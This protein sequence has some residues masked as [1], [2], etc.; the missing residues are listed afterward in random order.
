MTWP[1]HPAVPGCATV[2]WRARSR[3]RTWRRR[4]SS[5]N[6]FSYFDLQISTFWILGRDRATV[7]CCADTRAVVGSTDWLAPGQTWPSAARSCPRAMRRRAC[8]HQ[9][10]VRPALCIAAMA[11]LSPPLASASAAPVAQPLYKERPAG[12]VK[13]GQ[14]AELARFGG[15]R[16]IHWGRWVWQR[17]GRLRLAAKARKYS[18][19][20]RRA[21]FIST[22]TTRL[23]DPVGSSGTYSD[24]GVIDSRNRLVRL[25]EEVENRYR[26][27]T[28]SPHWRQ[29]RRPIRS[30]RISR[31]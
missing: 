25:Y 24:F 15:Q 31:S 19:T 21:S 11:A 27:Q 20:R 4:S 23:A 26:D 29:F 2:G 10:H 16:R 28:N 9:C 7:E 18:G 12:P 3:A 5:L 13:L 17:P 8:Q 14:G 30:S 22:D 6:T 1:I